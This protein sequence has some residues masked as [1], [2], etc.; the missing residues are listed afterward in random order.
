MKNTH[1]QRQVQTQHIRSGQQLL[2]PHPLRAPRRLRLQPPPVVINRPHPKRLALPHHIPPDP[3]HAQN[4]QR[5]PL[6]PR[7][8]APQTPIPKKESKK[9][10]KTNLRIPPQPPQT[11]PPP[12]LPQPRHPRPKPPQRPQ[13]EEDSRVR[14]RVVDGSRHV[15]HS[16]RRLARAA[17]RDVDLVVAGAVVRAEHQRRGQG[18]DEFGV[19][20]ARDGG[21]GEGPVGGGDAVEAAGAAFG[22]EGGAGC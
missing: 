21:A 17:S 2:E 9:K 5:L 14:R 15:A 8:S 7:V 12:P 1:I 18:G 11:R 13:H 4:P 10:Q 22:E 6:S 20:G 19:P 3:P 16:E